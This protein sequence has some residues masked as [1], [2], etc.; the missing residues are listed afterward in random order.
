MTSQNSRIVKYH[1]RNGHG[2]VAL[3]GICDIFEAGDMKEVFAK[4]IADDSVSQLSV[5]CKLLTRIDTSALQLLS[6]LKRSAELSG[7]AFAMVNKSEQ[8]QKYLETVGVTL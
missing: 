6:S 4:A 3:S 8:I 2:S 5:D 7:K 1:K